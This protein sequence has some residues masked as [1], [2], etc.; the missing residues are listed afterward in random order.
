MQNRLK[1]HKYFLLLITV[2]IVGT[3]L[4][5]LP[6]YLKGNY[7][8]GGGDVKTQ[9]YPF[10]VLNRR[11]TINALRDKTLP[12]YSFV[13]FLGNNIWASKSSYGLFDIYNILTY[14]LN[15]DYSISKNTKILQSSNRFNS[16]NKKYF[17]NTLALGKI[18]SLIKNNYN[19]KLLVKKGGIIFC[20]RKIFIILPE[21][22]KL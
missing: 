13:L 12:F 9:W 22:M 18:S 19:N 6:S 3:F 1:K 15:K 20:L 7:F 14:V 21:N 2:L 8:V 17:L 11:T 10:Y 4:M 16:K 5:F